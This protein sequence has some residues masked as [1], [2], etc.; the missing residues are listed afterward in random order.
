[1]GADGAIN[2]TASEFI[3][4]QKSAGW[5]AK[6]ATATLVLAAA[7]WYITKDKVTPIV[8]VVCAFTLGF[9]A[10][11]QPRQLQY[12]LD[13]HGI[14]IGEKFS[15]FN[16]FRSFSVVREGAFDSLVLMPLKRFAQLTTIY[17][18][19]ELADQIIAFLADRLPMEE[20]RADLLDRLMTHI[21]F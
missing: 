8:I 2:W 15:S 7:V 6:L 14:T 16:D 17:Y 1:V 12:R 13:D 20:R 21:H 3:A 9:Y 4:H 5:Y 19:P 10:S 11:R 18:A